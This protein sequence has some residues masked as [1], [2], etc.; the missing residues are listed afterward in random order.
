M[1]LPKLVI[2][3]MDPKAKQPTQQPINREIMQVEVRNPDKVLYSGPAVA[4]SSKNAV[5]PLDILPEHENF[6]SLLTDKITIWTDKR[7]KQDI[8]NTNAIAKNKLNKVSI[9]LGVETLAQNPA[10]L[11][12][13][14]K[15]GGR[16]SSIPSQ[17]VQ[18]QAAQPQ[19]PTQQSPK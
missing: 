7:Q 12:P 1:K 17:A 11:A 15:K 3:T 13:D 16:P 19:T 5:G 14:P 10:T 4:I 8:P 6:I 18:Q 2:S 9:F